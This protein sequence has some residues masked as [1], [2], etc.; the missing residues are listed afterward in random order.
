MHATPF[1]QP[2]LLDACLD[3]LAVAPGR[4][5]V[6]GTVGDG[7]HAAAIL[8]RSAPDGRLLGLDR[9]PHALARARTR[10]AR[11]GARVTLCHASFRELGALL[12]E[13][14]TPPVD[15][16]LLDLGVSS[17]QLDA[18]ARGFR[19][20]RESAERAPLDMRF[21]PT[22]PVSAASL[23]AQATVPALETLLREFGELPGARRLARAIG[24]A[25]RRA[26][27]KTAADLRRVIAA[28]GVGRGRRH[29]P[30][31]LVFQ[32]LRIAVNDELSALDDGLSAALDALAPGGR[33]AVIAYHSLED[34]RVKRRLAREER[35]CV[36]PP[37][38]PVCTCAHTPRVTRLTRRPER[39][40]ADECHAN[41][42]ARS[43]RLRTAQRLP[44]P[45]PPTTP[46]PATTPTATPS[47]TAAP[48][49][50]PSPMSTPTLAREPS[51]SPTLMPA[52]S[53]AP[54]PRGA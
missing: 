28:A 19:F 53:P 30:A 22:A 52:P 6:D 46:S 31:T 13:R 5:F 2:V 35:S 12:A 45:P 44:T 43:A 50:T 33:L 7:G 54:T 23:L 47:P 1:H 24:E 41:P 3:G 14:G 27:L 39:P 20:A 10:L 49:A 42:R 26:P 32:A 4:S 38:Q 21:D 34:R 17:P 37:A 11:F 18:P 48:T 40:D 9:D 16:V 8:E 36:C 15:G 29:N 25:R 51:S